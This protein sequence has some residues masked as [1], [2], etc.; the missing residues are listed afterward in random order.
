MYSSPGFW[1]LCGVCGLWK[2]VVSGVVLEGRP[3]SDGGWEVVCVRAE[4]IVLK[5]ESMSV[6]GSRD[7]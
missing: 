7:D 6:K 2:D 4:I 1:K 5:E 3:W